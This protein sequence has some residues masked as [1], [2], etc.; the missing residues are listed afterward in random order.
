[1]IKD[2][3]EKPVPKKAVKPR[4]RV[5]KEAK[6]EKEP[7]AVAEAKVD[8]IP[9][10]ETPVAIPETMTE[11]VASAVSAEKAAIPAADAA[12]PVSETTETAEETAKSTRYYEAVGRRKTAIA[13]VRMFTRGDKELIVNDKPLEK[14]FSNKMFRAVIEA[15]LV[16][17]NIPERFRIVARVKGGGSNSQAEAIRHGISRALVMFN[18]DF[19]KRLKKAG[20][21]TRDPRMKERKKP[22][23]KKARRAPQ[24]AKR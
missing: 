9:A 21:L 18:V 1:M 13:R 14:Y 8:A 12:I 24:W 17:M 6:E 15:P 3:K 19:K 5:K 11:P 4:V 20:Y 22:G 2:I 16:K 23:L 7:V 10:V